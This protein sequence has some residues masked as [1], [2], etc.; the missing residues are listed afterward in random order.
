MD[1]L[2]HGLWALAIFWGTSYRWWAF[3]IG[4]VPDL[5]SFGLVFVKEI[6]HLNGGGPPPI[7]SLPSWLP[8]MYS[9][10][11]SFVTW[12]AIGA[13]LYALKKKYWPI[14]AAA[15]AHIVLDIFTHCNYYPTPFLEPLTSY[16]YCGVSWGTPT[17]FIQNW[18]SLVIIFSMIGYYEWAKRKKGKTTGKV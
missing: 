10:T 15:M 1:T 17:I 13:L 12:I 16:R 11:H 5:L 7:E 2:S 8:T 3:L 6:G 4:M 9:I 18:I 14:V